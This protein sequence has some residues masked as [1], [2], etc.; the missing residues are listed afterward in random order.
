MSL[1]VRKPVAEDAVQAVRKDEGKS[2][3]GKTAKLIDLLI[4][5]HDTEQNQMA[6][7]LSDVKYPDYRGL[8]V[9]KFDK[10]LASPLKV[11]ALL[12]WCNNYDFNALS[13]YDLGTILDKKALRSAL[14]SFLSKVHAAGITSIAAVRGRGNDFDLVQRFEAEENHFDVYNME[15]EWWNGACTFTEYIEGLKIMYAKAK[16]KG[17]KAEEYIGYL[18]DPEDIKQ[19]PRKLIAKANKLI[20]KAKKMSNEKDKEEAET[21]AN[22]MIAKANELKETS[23]MMAKELVRYSHRTLVHVYTKTPNFEYARERLEFI[24]QAA[25]EL[26][27][28]NSEK[29]LPHEVVVL[30]SAETK[31]NGAGDFMGDYY[32]NNGRLSF[33]KAYFEFKKEY[34]K[35]FSNQRSISLVGYQVFAYSHA[36]EAQSSN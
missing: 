4:K 22:K 13:L 21:E 23:L 1:V 3:P 26:A 19:Q 34:D 27:A 35:Y 36:K 33:Q 2:G 31:V 17:H 20:K 8:Y 25:E 14:P 28:E 30:F 32:R 9:D 29:K 12:E 7:P 16:S 5:L 24:A 6:S 15:R 11:N 10:I 18:R